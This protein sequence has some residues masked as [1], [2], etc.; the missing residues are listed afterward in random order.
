MYSTCIFC[1]ADLGRNEVIEHFP[2]GR[3]LAF[4]AA[5]G[6]LW[7]VCRACGHWNLTPLEE[8]WEAVEEC[9]R[10]FRA[11]TLGA[12][13]D[14][15]GLS[16]VAGGLDLVRVGK[17]V[18]PEF[19]AW[20]YG[21]TLRRRHA[22]AM[23]LGAAAS[24]AGIVGGVAGGAA[25]VAG[26]SAV[27]AATGAISVVVLPVLWTAKGIERYLEHREYERV[28]ARVRVPDGPPR[29]VRAE[30]VRR[31]EIVA[32]PD[33]AAWRLSVTHSTGRAELEGADAAQA[34]GQLLARINSRGATRGEVQDAV[35]LIGDAGGPERFIARAAQLREHRRQRSMVFNDPTF[36][37]LGLREVERLAV[38]MAMNEDAERF[39]LEGE[40]QALEAAWRDAEELAAIS[41]NLLLPSRVREWLRGRSR[42]SS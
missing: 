11:A 13:T 35:R 22:R 1:H 26:L 36:G 41:D 28:V 15:I 12:S 34:G 33:G 24:T 8:R 7:V 19:A 4:D 3:R 25:L 21:G 9:E 32:P 18:R 39:A 23:A 42:S 2:V 37:A 40:L 6:R 38:E 30:H 16:H 31:L 29:E 17:P 14:Q 20:R 5:K 27:V 10:L